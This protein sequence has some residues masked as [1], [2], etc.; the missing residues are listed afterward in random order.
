MHNSKHIDFQLTDLQDQ[1]SVTLRWCSFPEWD[2]ACAPSAFA[3]KATNTTTLLKYFQMTFYL[4]DL[5][6]QKSLTLC[7]HSFWEWGNKAILHC[8]D[9][10]GSR[11]IE[12]ELLPH[13]AIQIMQDA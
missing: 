9:W 6:D 5:Q 2:R 1:Q 12:Y 3:N 13:I 10:Q 11:Y 7:W 4:P 8:F